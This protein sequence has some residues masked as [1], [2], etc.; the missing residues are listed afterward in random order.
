MMANCGR[1][2]SLVFLSLA[3][4]EDTGLSKLLDLGVAPTEEVLVAPLVL[5]ALPAERV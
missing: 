2:I 1:T 4:E 5:R 3:T